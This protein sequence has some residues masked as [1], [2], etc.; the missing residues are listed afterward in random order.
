VTDDIVTRLQQMLDGPVPFVVGREDIRE[1]ADEIARLREKVEDL[2]MYLE[3][4]ACEI[5]RLRKEADEERASSK[6]FQTLLLD[7]T[8]ELEQVT[9][10]RNGWQ[11]EAGGI[12]EDLSNAEDEIERLQEEINDLRLQVVILSIPKETGDD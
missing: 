8:D 7:A 3:R 5:E 2:R 12:S 9:K 6:T 10:E 1:A 11:A 4:D